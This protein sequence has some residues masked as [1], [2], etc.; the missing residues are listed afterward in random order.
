[1]KE[2]IVN[3]KIIVLACLVVTFVVKASKPEL[4]TLHLSTTSSLVV[5]SSKNLSNS[6]VVAR[7]SEPDL[8]CMSYDELVKDWNRVDIVGNVRDPQV[9]HVIVCPETDSWLNVGRLQLYDIYNI[10]NVAVG[11][12]LPWLKSKGHRVVQRVQYDAISCDKIKVFWTIDPD[13]SYWD[14]VMLYMRKKNGEWKLVKSIG[15]PVQCTK[16]SVVEKD[17]A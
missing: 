1:M 9:S 10:Y 13:T 11:A 2:C 8:C 15:L 16:R 5:T 7:A 3:K 4:R 14:R 12:V 6:P 17:I